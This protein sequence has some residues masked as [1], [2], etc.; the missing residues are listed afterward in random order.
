MPSVHGCSRLTSAI[1][2][3][4]LPVSWSVDLDR[5]ISLFRMNTFPEGVHSKG[6]LTGGFYR[7]LATSVDI[8]RG[9]EGG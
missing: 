9:V 4:H 2:G 3:T 6:E 5:K 8:L 1:T 7:T